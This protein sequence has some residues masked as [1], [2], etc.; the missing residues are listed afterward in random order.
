M[1]EQG[2][3]NLLA[4]T[5]LNR[6]TI[7]AP[8]LNLDQ[9]WQDIRQQMYSDGWYDPAQASA[10][11]FFMDFTHGLLQNSNPAPGINVKYD[12]NNPSGANLDQLRVYTRRVFSLLS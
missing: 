3:N 10:G 9:Y 4:D 5:I 6:L 2:A 8:T 1:P 11:H 12:V 7:T